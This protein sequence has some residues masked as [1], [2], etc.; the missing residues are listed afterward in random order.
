[1]VEIENCKKAAEHNASEGRQRLMSRS[2][3]VQDPRL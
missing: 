1:M 3:L 2:L